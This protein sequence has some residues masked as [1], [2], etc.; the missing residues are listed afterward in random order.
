M[1]AGGGGAGGGGGGPGGA[2]GGGV[3]AGGGIGRGGSIGGGVEMGRSGGP[4]LVSG[5]ARFDQSP[6]F[7]VG[8]AESANKL[9]G[10]RVEGFNFGSGWA[11][12]RMGSGLPLVNEGPA[13]LAGLE[14]TMKLANGQGEPVNAIRFNNPVKGSASVESLPA[15]TEQA[16]VRA[17]EAIIAQ[18]RQG[19]LQERDLLKENE[20]AAKANQVPGKIQPKMVEGVQSLIAPEKLMHERTLIRSSTSALFNPF[21]SPVLEPEIKAENVLGVQAGSR[22]KVENRISAAVAL[23]VLTQPKLQ[24]HEVE[25]VV[26]EM[27]VSEKT[28]TIEEEE[29]EKIR[30]KHIVDGRALLR[31]VIEFKEAVNKAKELAVKLGIKITGKLIS[32]FLPGQHAG[33][34]SEAV[35]GKGPDGSIP[36]RQQSVEELGE[37]SS[38][39]EAEERVVRE[40]HAKP[41][42][43]IREEGEQV[44]DEHVQRVYKDHTT[45]P[46]AVIEFVTRIIK[47]KKPVIQS[48][49]KI[50]EA[51]QVQTSENKIEDL[52]LAEVFPKAA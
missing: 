24:E 46:R 49:Q 21:L 7:G 10:V 17:A 41:P 15:Q 52:G 44:A 18:A 36:E 11:R 3:G 34:E 35:K 13:G 32:K 50:A 27:V 4:A 39:V 48:G 51:P 29:I 16:A 38:E 20:V 12:A 25:E 30:K 33:N 2:G 9:G 42:L 47:K 5:L 19:F 40:A 28:D 23:N 26:E 22:A 31:V 14:N 43:K 37:F 45:K 8:P 6:T 1:N